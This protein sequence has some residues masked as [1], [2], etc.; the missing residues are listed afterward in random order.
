MENI[1]MYF[2][3]S[4]TERVI[5]RN[6][7]N[8]MKTEQ[9]IIITTRKHMED[10]QVLKFNQELFFFHHFSLITYRQALHDKVKI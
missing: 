1:Q 7:V 8:S 9:K 5:E 6:T 2:K 3:C 4:A 10:E